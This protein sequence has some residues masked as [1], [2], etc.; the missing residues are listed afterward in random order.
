MQKLAKKV[1]DWMFA[2]HGPFGWNDPAGFQDEFDSVSPALQAEFT[3]ELL[4][5]LQ[6]RLA[7]KCN[8]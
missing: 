1:A 8:G 7:E 3:R 2:D 5:E 4:S 6:R